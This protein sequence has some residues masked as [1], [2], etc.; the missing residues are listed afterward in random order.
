MNSKDISDKFK[1]ELDLLMNRPDIKA[2]M[3]GLAMYD[4]QY[5][6]NVPKKDAKKLFPELFENED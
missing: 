3:Y 2:V 6:G 5:R 1:E 4:K